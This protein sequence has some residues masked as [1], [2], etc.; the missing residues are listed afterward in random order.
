MY[1]ALKLIAF[2]AMKS[3]RNEHEMHKPTV[4]KRITRELHAVSRR[5]CK[6]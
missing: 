1:I 5:T 4:S 6:Q 3:A 2:K